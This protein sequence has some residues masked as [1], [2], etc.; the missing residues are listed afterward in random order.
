MNFA[1]IYNL[2]TLLP[3]PYGA[4]FLSEEGLGVMRTYRHAVRFFHHFCR[5]RASAVAEQQGDPF[6]R[7][8][9]FFSSQGRFTRRRFSLQNYIFTS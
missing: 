2:R 1:I 3:S 5:G 4:T 7:K 8:I 6:R 9:L